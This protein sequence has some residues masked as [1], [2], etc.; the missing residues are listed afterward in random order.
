MIKLVSETVVPLNVAQ[1]D[2]A[3][4]IGGILTEEV[5][6]RGERLAGGLQF[7]TSW[8]LRASCSLGQAK[9]GLHGQFDTVVNADH[10]DS[11]VEV[12]P[13]T[14]MIGRVL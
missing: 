12:A 9:I 4:L 7:S 1:I 10:R 13:E 11:S 14:K 6:E 2:S 3:K 5:E 8:T